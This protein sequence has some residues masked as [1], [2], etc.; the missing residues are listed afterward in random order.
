MGMEIDLMANYPRSKRNVEER[1]AQKTEAD[2]AV[3]RRFGKEFFD[4]SRDQGYGGF[5]YH[6]RFWEAV[7]PDFQRHFGL[8]AGDS[9]L[10]IG[11]AKGFMLYDMMRLIPGINVRGIDVSEYAIE[12]AL[13]EVKPF[14]SVGDARKL[15]FPDKSFDV[16]ISITTIHNLE[17]DECAVALQ[18][19][20]RVARRGA[21]ITL[22]AYRDDNEKARMEAWNLTAKTMMHVD[23]WKAFFRQVGYTG[24][25]YW[26]IP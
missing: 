11:C 6:P 13:P 15:P 3:A 9:V 10:D 12:H 16:V 7:I 22:D 18:E 1:G 5:N 24:D 17:R 8:K 4:G 2:R 26:F 19:V 23:E 25:Y 20:E 21:F 14:V